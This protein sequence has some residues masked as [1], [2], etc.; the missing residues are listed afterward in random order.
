M[1]I[2]E[3]I[4][5][6]SLVVGMIFC[7]RG[8]LAPIDESLKAK[9]SQWLYYESIGAIDT[10]LRDGETINPRAMTRDEFSAHVCM[11]ASRKINGIT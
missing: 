8:L 4:F 11:C 10:F 9:D 2:L 1:G 6:A 3:F 5:V 7:V